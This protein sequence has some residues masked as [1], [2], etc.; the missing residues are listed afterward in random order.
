MT[1]TRRGL[2][3]LHTVENRRL[4]ESLAEARREA[5]LTQY[6]LAAQLKVDQTY[7]SKYESCRRRLDVIEFLRIVAV[8]GADPSVLLGRAGVVAES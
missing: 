3:G 7:V 8:I 4:M 5:G 1:T 2:T 6:E